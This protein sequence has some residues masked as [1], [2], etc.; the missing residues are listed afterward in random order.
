[1]SVSERK[2]CR[3]SNP[4]SDEDQPVAEEDRSGRGTVVWTFDE[5]GGDQGVGEEVFGETVVLLDEKGDASS[6][7]LGVFER[8]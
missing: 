1:M 2:D 6:R 8:S 4:A 3:D 7:V 5:G